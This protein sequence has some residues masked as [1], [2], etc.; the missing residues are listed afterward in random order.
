MQAF[1]AQDGLSR[2]GEKIARAVQ[3]E[4][5][6][7]VGL[8]VGASSLWQYLASPACAAGSEAVL[9][10]G[11]R[12]RD[13]R[14]LRPRCATE[15]VFAA[16]EASFDPQALATELQGHVA[17]C[18]VVAGTAHGF[19]NPA[20]PNFLPVL[21]ASEVERLRRRLVALQGR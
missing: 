11:S 9:Y 13:H 14:A 1:H 18:S 16:R 6:F 2:Y 4:A 7:L 10:Y 20:S 15:L 5:A 21:A 12:I 8:S 19:M 17:A 3:G